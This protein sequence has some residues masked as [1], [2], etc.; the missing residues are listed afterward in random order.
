MLS[1]MFFLASSHTKNTKS[2]KTNKHTIWLIYPKK[3]FEHMLFS[4]VI[5]IAFAHKKKFLKKLKRKQFQNRYQL[6][7]TCTHSST[8]TN[9]YHT[10]Y[11][12]HKKSCPSESNPFYWMFYETCRLWAYFGIYLPRMLVRFGFVCWF[13]YIL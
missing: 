11:I 5:I 8:R 4:K 9:R 13:H 6:L 1:H 10:K 3:R 2:E 7:G 12:N